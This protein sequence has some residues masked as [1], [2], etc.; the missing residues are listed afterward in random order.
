MFS[1]ITSS[2]SAHPVS[3]CRRVATVDTPSPGSRCLHVNSDVP[4]SR[5]C[6]RVWA[7]HSVTQLTSPGNPSG[8]QSLARILPQGIPSGRM[9]CRSD[10]DPCDAAVREAARAPGRARAPDSQAL[11]EARIQPPDH[12]RR[13]GPRTTDRAK[14]ERAALQ[15]AARRARRV[16]DP[17]SGSH[18]P[19][20]REHCPLCPTRPG[21]EPTE[22]PFARSRSSSSRT[23]SRFEAPHGAAEVVVY[24]DR[25]RRLLRDPPSRSA[26][27]S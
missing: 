4:V 14:D 1:D 26:P 24:T 22:I 15:R 19:A 12:R 8:S 9:T 18:V 25:P 16:R 6:S 17:A 21:C 11:S 2:S 27:R 10:E 7:Q 5:L 13:A 23:A 3:R 20:R